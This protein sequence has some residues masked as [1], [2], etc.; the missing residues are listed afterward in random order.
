MQAAS[1]WTVQPD[2]ARVI[3]GLAMALTERSPRLAQLERRMREE[4]ATSLV[5]WLDHIAVHPQPG[6]EARWREAGFSATTRDGV[7]IWRHPGG[8]FPLLV[9]DPA[10]DPP[11]GM[12]AGLRVDAVADA[13]TALRGS[14]EPEGEP[15]AA[16]RRA[17]LWTESGIAVLAVERHG[18]PGF[19]LPRPRR[20]E[21]AL[22][23]QESFRLRRR[24][25]PE[26]EDG[27]AELHRLIDRAIA[28][29]GRDEACDRFFAAE[30]DYWQH[31]NRAARIQKGRQD[32]LGLGWANHDHHTYRSS[33]RWYSSLIAV[34]E[35]LGL[36]CR[37]R[38]HAG[39]EAGW[40]AQV[41]E[42]PVT[43]IVVFADVDL[44]PEEIAGDIAHSPL[45]R[46]PRL[47]TIGL[48]CGLHG[49]AILDAG[50][51]HL[52]CTFL[53]DEL[54]TQL[55]AFGVVMMKPFTDFPH[56]KQAFTQ[57]ERWAVEESRL[58]H[59]LIQGAITMEQAATF[60]A[61][62]AIGSHLENLE[63]RQGFKGFNQHGVSRI[64]AGTDPR[65]R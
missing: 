11:D 60:R 28:E 35:K 26:P 45:P 8:R 47:G 58:E 25:F 27:F 7:T 41:L 48:W 50:M 39:A 43:G 62:G 19:A 17:R 59:L 18:W 23:V 20:P 32:A 37:E 53:H 49:E 15:L 51:H 5:D 2:A 38:F 31:R 34:L 4:T 13:L 55:A 56:L 33:R 30:R 36:E 24:N 46:L 1:Q 63:R 14:G 9:S 42:H 61:E 64:I 12:V 52:E 57:G 16:Y 10:L 6:V 21:V 29:V 3:A 44:A 40:G 65:L 22:R 54:T